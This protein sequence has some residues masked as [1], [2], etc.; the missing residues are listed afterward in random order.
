LLR[1]ISALSLGVTIAALVIA[2]LLF[3]WRVSVAVAVGYV[4]WVVR[5]HTTPR[6]PGRLRTTV[7]FVL[8]ALIGMALGAFALGA[9]G[10]IFGFVFGF[11]FRLAEVPITGVFSSREKNG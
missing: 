7:E 8:F 5:L 4:L 6:E 3:G 10:G 1:I 2:G 11:A 9:L